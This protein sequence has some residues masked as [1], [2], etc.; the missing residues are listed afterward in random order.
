MLISQNIFKVD[1]ITKFPLI[2]AHGCLFKEKGSNRIIP[3][4]INDIL[5]SYRNSE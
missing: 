4:I 3:V 1:I 5:P 2:I